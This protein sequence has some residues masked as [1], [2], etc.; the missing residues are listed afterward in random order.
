MGVMFAY[1]RDNNSSAPFQNND[2]YVV[3]CLSVTFMCSFPALHTLSILSKKFLSPTHPWLNQENGCV[4]Q[5]R[6]SGKLGTSA[7]GVPQLAYKALKLIGT[8]CGRTTGQP[9]SL[10]RAPAGGLNPTRE[11]SRR[12][13][14]RLRP[15]G[16]P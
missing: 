16:R 4:A 2:T 15:T 8:I 12:A 6:T 3:L 14:G 13:S 11:V 10:E 5:T 1:A 7:K 9:S